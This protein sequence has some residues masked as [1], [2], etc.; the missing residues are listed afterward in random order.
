MRET[1]KAKAGRLVWRCAGVALVLV[2]AA[3]GTGGVA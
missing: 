3:C 1:W 2:T